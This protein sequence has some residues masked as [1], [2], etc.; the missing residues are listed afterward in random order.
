MINKLL[1]KEYKNVCDRIDK[2]TLNGS[3]DALHCGMTHEYLIKT[4]SVRNQNIALR[5]TIH[6]VDNQEQY[7]KMIKN[8]KCG[9]VLVRK[10]LTYYYLHILNSRLIFDLNSA[11]EKY[12]SLL[13]NDT[14]EYRR[15]FLNRQNLQTFTCF[16]NNDKSQTS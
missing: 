16:V 4:Y 3:Y 11:F 9:I 5:F 14:K 12:K 13:L 6:E 8:H 7:D 2:I 15:N 1:P 10:T